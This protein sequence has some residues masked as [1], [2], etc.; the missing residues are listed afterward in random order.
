[1]RS[2]MM[3][4]MTHVVA[5]PIGTADVAAVCKFLH[6][7]LNPA[8]PVSAWRALF[9]PPWPGVGPNHGFQLLA[10]D[11]IVGAYVA[12]YSHRILGS[13]SEPFCNLAAFCVREEYRS[14]SFR[15]VRA[16]LGQGGYTFTDLSPSGN[17]IALNQ[18]LGFTSLDTSTAFV[19]N[20]P[21][22][23]QRHTQIIADP[24]RIESL[25]RGDDLRIYHDH[26]TAAAARHIVAVHG[27]RIGYL[28]VRRDRR[29]NLPLFASVLHAGGD[30][31]LLR[32]AWPQ[33][34]TQL[35]RTLHTPVTLAELRVLGFEPPLSIPLRK[36]RPKMF[37]SSTVTA[38][39]IDLLYSELTLLTW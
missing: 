13:S 14:H 36:S 28:V 17:V 23:A 19:L 11:R 4:R 35:L 37:R 39:D 5:R 21:A 7:E 8:V 25:L 27:E 31:A 34:R 33:L 9:S 20:V 18:R 38:S 6:D 16:I 26:R 15:L 30:R 29:R 3:R 12:V 24:A 10:D 32:T 1:M 22:P 2:R